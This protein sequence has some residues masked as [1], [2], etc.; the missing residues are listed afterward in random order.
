MADLDLVRRLVNADHGLAIVA[1]ARDDGSVQTSLVNAGVLDDPA[2]GQPVVGFVAG[3][4]TYKLRRLRAGTRPT[5]VLRAGWEWVSVDGPVRLAGPDDGN[6]PGL[7]QLLRD[8][9]VAAGGTHDDWDEYDR[10]MAA[11]RRTAV[12]VTPARITSNG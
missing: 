4:G 5:I 12:L 6:P 3:G 9:F 1:L 7:A 11:E 10:V 2:T 8:V